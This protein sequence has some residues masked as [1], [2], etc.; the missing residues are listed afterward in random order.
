MRF[1]F[2]YRRVRKAPAKCIEGRAKLGAEVVG[3]RAAAACKGGRW[4]AHEPPVRARFDVKTDFSTCCWAGSRSYTSRRVKRGHIRFA[5][6]D[7]GPRG[8][9]GTIRGWWGARRG[10]NRCCTRN[11]SGDYGL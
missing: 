5:A 2:V 7:S 9:R 6:F 10:R 11:G 1:S 4:A 8:G 3:T